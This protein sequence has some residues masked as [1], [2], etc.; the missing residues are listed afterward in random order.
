MMDEGLFE[1]RTISSTYTKTNSKWLKDINVRTETVKLLEENI[2]RIVFDCRISR[3][4]L[5]HL[6]E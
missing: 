4:S 3:S 5:I 1:I 6:L 2:C